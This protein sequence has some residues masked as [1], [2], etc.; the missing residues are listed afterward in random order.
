MEEYK[1][2]KV[3]CY[4][5]R[6]VQRR[7]RGETRQ[8]EFSIILPCILGRRGTSCHEQHPKDLPLTHR[9][10]HYFIH[11]QSHDKELLVMIQYTE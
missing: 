1:S 6:L 5:Q 3:N 7:R 9:Q 8:V 10:W 11:I 4:P 2:T